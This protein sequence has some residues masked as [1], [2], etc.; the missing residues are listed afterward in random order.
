VGGVDAQA[1]GIGGVRVVVDLRGRRDFHVLGPDPEFEIGDG[2]VPGVG[3]AV[4][5][6]IA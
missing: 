3:D 6:G 2:L 1:E 4:V 5:H